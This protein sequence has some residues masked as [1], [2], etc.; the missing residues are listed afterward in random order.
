MNTERRSEILQQ[1]AS[2]IARR[3]L[4]APARFALDIVAP[5]G[6]IAGQVAQL[7]Q[8]LTPAG[9]WHDYVSALDDEQGWAV[10]QR[11]VDRQDG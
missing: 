5:L 11:L 4:T 10:L 8:P 2:A 1:L 3:R 7:V 6:F 9:R